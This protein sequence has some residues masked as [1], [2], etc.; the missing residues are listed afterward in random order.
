METAWILPSSSAVPTTEEL[1][2]ISEVNSPEDDQGNA[3]NDFTDIPIPVV[4]DNL[5]GAAL[6]GSDNLDDNASDGFGPSHAL[7]ELPVL[8]DFDHCD[9]VSSVPNV[10]TILDAQSIKEFDNVDC[11]QHEY[12]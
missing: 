12:L 11:F 10:T 7:Q 1:P 2:D 6:P 9:D 3:V 8:D 5:N 4:S